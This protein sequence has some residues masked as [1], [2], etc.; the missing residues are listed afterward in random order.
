LSAKLYLKNFQT[1]EQNSD[2]YVFS[3]SDIFS[4]PK[5]K[6]NQERSKIKK[7]NLKAVETQKD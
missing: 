3:D 6:M 7:S 1:K 4:L 5:T 2:S